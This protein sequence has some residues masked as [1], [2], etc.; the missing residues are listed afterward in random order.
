VR[1]TVLASLDPAWALQLA[2]AWAGAGDQVTLVL[3]DEAAALARAGHPQTAGVHAAVEDGVTVLADEDALLRRGISGGRFAD[4][5]KR[6]SLD[7]VA[8]LLADA[9]DRAVWL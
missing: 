1:R 2:S 5:V 4:G 3:L 8:D 7:E 9:T 6:A